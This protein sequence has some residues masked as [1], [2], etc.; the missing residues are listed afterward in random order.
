MHSI[1]MLGRPPVF[2]ANGTFLFRSR[3]RFS[4]HVQLGRMIAERCGGERLLD[5]PPAEFRRC[6]LEER[7][8]HP[9]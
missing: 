2:S 5:Y 1:H 9:V 6:M 7:H 8:G 4:E 3:V